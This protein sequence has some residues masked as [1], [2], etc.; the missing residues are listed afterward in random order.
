MAALLNINDISE[1]IA[2]SGLSDATIAKAASVG[3][4]TV[5]RLRVGKS[6]NPEYATIG[7]IIALLKPS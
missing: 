3:R 4:S 7:R 6:K 2:K 5:W 1:L